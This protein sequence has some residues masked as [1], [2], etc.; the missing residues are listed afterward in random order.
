MTTTMSVVY[1]QETVSPL[2][3]YMKTCGEDVS[4]DY[5]QAL[6][7]CGLD[8]TAKDQVRCELHL[9]KTCLWGLRPGPTQ[10]WLCT[11]TEDG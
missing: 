2:L 1:F 5:I 6:L 8:I 11:A 9:E 4:T 10:T 7:R 3:I